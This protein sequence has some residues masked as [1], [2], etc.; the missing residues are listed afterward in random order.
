[1]TLEVTIRASKEVKGIREQSYPPLGTGLLCYSLS[2]PTEKPCYP[3]F[4][5]NVILELRSQLPHILP[6]LRCLQMH[7]HLYKKVISLSRGDLNMLL[8]LGGFSQHPPLASAL[9]WRVK[10]R[11]LHSCSLSSKRMSLEHLL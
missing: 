6:A 1:M 3:T 4:T 2:Y 10:G 8:N 5:G 11:R 7:T 9:R